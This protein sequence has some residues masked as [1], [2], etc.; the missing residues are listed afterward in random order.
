[1]LL[2]SEPRLQCPDCGKF[3]HNKKYLLR[4]AICRPVLCWVTLMYA[5]LPR[6]TF[7]MF[8]VLSRARSGFPV[9]FSFEFDINFVSCS[10]LKAK[11][12]SGNALLPVYSRTF[13]KSFARRFS[14]THCIRA[15]GPGIRSGPVPVLYN[16]SPSKKQLLLLV[17]CCLSVV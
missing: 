15:V 7:T 4:S 13:L 9:C 16:C 10:C 12:H 1:M 2:H 5:S 14:A 8:S 6:N 11:A 3:F 17:K